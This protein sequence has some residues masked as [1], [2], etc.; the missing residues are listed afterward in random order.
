MAGDAHVAD[1]FEPRFLRRVEVERHMRTVRREPLDTAP[2]WLLRILRADALEQ[3]H[4]LLRFTPTRRRNTNCR[5]R[6]IEHVEIA[7]ERLLLLH[8]CF[9]CQSRPALLEE[10]AEI[11][12]FPTAWLERTRAAGMKR[13]TERR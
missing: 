13:A 7:D 9:A 6:A 2:E 4:D 10:V 11:A 12:G 3:S 5:R 8:A 1:R